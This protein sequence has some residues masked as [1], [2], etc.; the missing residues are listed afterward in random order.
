VVDPSLLRQAADRGVT[1]CFADLD[2][3]DGLWVPEER[4][5]L[6]NRRLSDRQVAEV[7]EHELG[8]VDID[9]QHAN[10]DAGVSRPRSAPRWRTIALTVA[11]FLAAVG[12][13]TAGLTRDDGGAVRDDPVVAPTAPPLTV[14]PSGSPVVQVTAVRDSNG[15]IVLQTVTVTATPTAT[16]AAATSTGPAAPTSTPRVSR[17]VTP[18][19]APSGTPP[20]AT[21]SPTPAP[22]TTPPPA[23]TTPPAPTASDTP[24]DTGDG[25]Q[26][27]SVTA[28]PTGSTDAASGTP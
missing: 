3:A 11:A 27:D 21:T 26:G 7:I 15:R 5:V 17:S 19:P 4:T 16:P 13:L 24:A 1:I 20:P 9:D 10:L 28:V 2:G 23:T 14:P 12:G 25:L 22:T 6:V 8:H 18:P